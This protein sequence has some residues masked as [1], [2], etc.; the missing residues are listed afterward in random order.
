[1]SAR[2]FGKVEKSDPFSARAG[3][4][5]DR[6]LTGQ[7]A[8]GGRATPGRAAAPPARSKG[9]RGALRCARLGISTPR[10]SGRPWPVLSGLKKAIPPPQ[11]LYAFTVFSTVYRLRNRGDKLPPDAIKQGS[12]RGY[13]RMHARLRR[14]GWPSVMLATLCTADYDYVIPCLDAARVLKIERGGILVTGT[15]VIPRG[16]SAKRLTADRF[17]QAW[18]CIPN[19]EQERT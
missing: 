6:A 5:L 3:R 8:S 9:G 19:L 2:P 17:P 18:W 7:A 12:S 4:G 1:M 10:A 16:R 11:I 13:L 14:P 15:E